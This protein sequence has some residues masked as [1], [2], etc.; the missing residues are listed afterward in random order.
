MTKK[1]RLEFLFRNRACPKGPLT[2]S[3]RSSYSHHISNLPPEFPFSSS[4][5]HLPQLSPFAD[6]LS[7][8]R[9][10]S[11]LP[12]VQL[13]FCLILATTLHVAGTH[14]DSATSA[15]PRPHLEHLITPLKPS[16]PSEKYCSLCSSFSA[17]SYPQCLVSCI[18]RTPRS[19]G[20][21]FKHQ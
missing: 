14:F 17:P 12:T 15:M 19:L 20:W 6:T 21:P 2:T 1:I 16:P 3:C 13:I 9:K 4:P 5:P 8:S 7:P 18:R 11:L 10:P